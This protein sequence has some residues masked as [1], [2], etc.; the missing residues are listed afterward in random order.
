MA[1]KALLISLGCSKNL[2]DSERMLAILEEA[3]FSLVSDPARAEAIVINTCGFLEEAVEEAI[4]TILEYARYKERGVCR[5]LVVTGCMVQRYGKKLLNLL[6]EVDLF[7]G[8]AHYDDVA[9]ELVR[10]LKNGERRLKISSP[11]CRFEQFR[12]R[13]LSTP[14][15]YAYL[16]IAEGCSHRCAYCY[17]PRIRGPFRSRDFEDVLR[18]V[19]Y[20]DGRDVKEVVLVAQDITSYGLDRR[21]GGALPRLLK[22]INATTKNIRWIRVLYAHPATIS[23]DFLK[24][25]ADLEK[26]V[27]YLDVPLQHC[28]PG[29]LRTM[30]RSGKAL[31]PGG[32]V[33]RIRSLWP[34]VAI[35]T[36]FIVGYPGETDADF[37]ELVEF[38]KAYRFEHLGVF[39]FSPEMGTKAARM[40]GQVSESVRHERRDILYAVQTEISRSRLATFVNRELPV[41]VDTE[42]PEGNFSLIGRT[43]WQAPEVDGCVFIENGFTEP[44]SIVRVRITGA[45]DFDL[46]GEMVDG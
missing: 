14:P 5:V 17:I 35:R 30:G 20:L 10:F 9:E 27:P 16:K 42:D 37:E 15:S 4:D 19:A 33:E 36:T 23:D 40:E 46:I 43:E 26:V 21:D 32:V 8:T 25:C 6:P 38:V 41:I 34:G 1:K 44:G 7:L 29:I 45:E 3:G 22:T 13:I 31:E 18:E 28:V 12:G 11:A 24:T 2:V 39:A